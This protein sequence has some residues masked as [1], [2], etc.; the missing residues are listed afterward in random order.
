[1]MFKK[2]LPHLGAIAI[3]LVVCVAY[4]SPQMN[5]KVIQQSDVTQYRGM[6]QEIRDFKEETGETTL[7]T[8]AMFGG[9]PTYQINT[10]HAGNNLRY[11]DKVNRLFVKHPIGR[12]FAAMVGFYILLVV[13]GVNPW[14]SI[15]GAVAFS[16]TTNNFLLYETGHMTKLRVVS[17]FPLMI[18]G[19]LLAFKPS[20][21][22]TWQKYALGGI[23][24]ALGLGLSIWANHV[25][26]TYYLFLTLLI[27]GVVQL[28]HDVRQGRLQEFL[29]GAGVLIVAGLIGLGSSA[30]NLWVTYEYSKDTMRGEPILT[31]SDTGQTPQNS[32]ETDGLAWDYAMQWSNGTIDI[33]ASFI[34]GVAGGGSS[35][36]VG[37]SSPL[38]KDPRWRQLMQQSGN[39]APLYWGALPFTSGPIYFGAIIVFL[40]I[41]GLVVVDGPVKWW[42]GLGT[43][44]TFLL[45][46]GKNMEA[47]NEFFFYYVPL[48]NKFRTP[49]SV[50][51]VTSFLMPLL[52][53]LALG[54]ILAGEIAK[55]KALR[56][57]YIAGGI[58]AAICLFFAL[59]GPSFFDFSSAGDA[60][61]EQAGY[62]VG[63]L[64]DARK[65]LMQSDAWR[66]FFLVVLSGG[67]LWAYL[68]EKLNQT[69]VIAGISVLVVFDLWSVGKRYLNEGNFVRQAS[70]EN[71]FQPSAAD[72]QILADP[73]PNFRVFDLSAQGSP[74]QSSRASYHHK[75]LGGYHAA[76]LQRYD[77]LIT[78]HLGQ[79]NQKV[80]DMLNA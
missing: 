30:S 20:D 8:N 3:F 22:S 75:S 5:G 71:A 60:R 18:A 48:F 63:P 73:D 12:F 58:C 40:F 14:L 34:P 50:L 53:F 52:G 35:E 49:N 23:L 6:S 11:L 57:L 15:A 47:I 59:M 62:P 7:W 64:M 27:F 38:K 16:F 31:S 4:F 79:G 19:M 2:I 32:S 25:Q 56:G 39:Y 51:T 70:Y 21:N 41:L 77:D 72:E 74:F 78:R 46:M 54:K 13:L 1:M 80:I 45:S 24:F 33:F 43:L 10:I 66:T 9:M 36:Q 65:S 76:K 42:L 67:L 69:I 55:E 44:L 26:M 17:Y 29:K 28:I 61:Y 68:K 37:S